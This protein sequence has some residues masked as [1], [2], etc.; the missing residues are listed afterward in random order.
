MFCTTLLFGQNKSIDSLNIVL[1]NAKNDIIKA[2]TLNAIA[3]IYKTSNPDLMK[4]YATK[5][6][7]LSQKIEYKIEEGFAN[8]NLPK[9]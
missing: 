1:K 5:A 8:L 4:D 6:L 7:Q 2:E 3:D 9:L